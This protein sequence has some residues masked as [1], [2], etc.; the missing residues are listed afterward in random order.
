MDVNE[1]FCSL[2][3]FSA[4]LN[5]ITKTSVPFL[6]STS[7]TQILH[8]RQSACIC[9]DAKP[10]KYASLQ[11]AAHL[12]MLQVKILLS[13]KAKVS[14]EGA[15]RLQTSWDYF[16]PS[17]S[18]Q[19]RPPFLAMLNQK[20]VELCQGPFH[21]PYVFRVNNPK[22]HENSIF[23]WPLQGANILKSKHSKHAKLSL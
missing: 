11:A 8:T 7:A 3:Y 5:F 2:C 15:F 18:S 21:Y 1:N 4:W 19:P 23:T 17:E 22:S 12:W 13:N 6:Q 14:K 16:F 9:L 20:A 10:F